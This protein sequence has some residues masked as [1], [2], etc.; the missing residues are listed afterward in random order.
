MSQLTWWSFFFKREGFLRKRLLWRTVLVT[1]PSVPAWGKL[2][3][4]LSLP[5]S[6]LM[7]QTVLFLLHS[8]L[9]LQSRDNSTFLLLFL[10][11]LWWMLITLSLISRMVSLSSHIQ[12]FVFMFIT[13]LNVPIQ[14][15]SWMNQP[16]YLYINMRLLLSTDPHRAVDKR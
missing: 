8:F 3:S 10:R 6:S 1:R 4:Y 2:F 15:K 11:M 12:P 7:M 13:L 16:I 5:L 14:L 9:H